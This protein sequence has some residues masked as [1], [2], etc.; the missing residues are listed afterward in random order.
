MI[1]HELAHTL[2][3]GS[4]SRARA[5]RISIALDS[6]EQGVDRLP[7]RLR[8]LPMQ[9]LPAPPILHRQPQ[10]K[11]PIGSPPGAE[12]TPLC[13]STNCSAIS[14]DRFE[15]QPPELQRVLAASLQDPAT[16]LEHLDSDRR[17]ALIGIFNRMCKYG[18]WC[19]VRQFLKIEPGDLPV[20][21]RFLIPGNTSSAHFVSRPWLALYNALMATGRFCQ[22]SGPGASRHPGQTTLREIS[23]SDSLHISLGPG[24]L[25]DAHID[26]YSPVTEHP[27]GSFCP[28]EPSAAAVGHIGRE[29]VPELVRKGVNIFGVHI[30]GPPG[31]QVFPEPP[32]SAPLP[33]GVGPRLSPE[34]VRITTLRGPTKK[35]PKPLVQAEAESASPSAGVLSAEI[36]EKIRQALD[37]QVSHEALLPSPVRASVTY[38]REAAEMAGPGEEAA[39]RAAREAVE[40]KASEY[41]DA[42]DVAFDLA[43]AME[44]ARWRH[45]ASVRLDLD[46]Y[47]RYGGLDPNG[48]KFIVGEI[49]RIALILRNYLPDRAAGVATVVLIFGSDKEAVREEVRLP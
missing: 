39:L 25:F 42:H 44:Q 38:A 20:A 9:P 7:A 16:W 32:P 40:K 45:L 19:H 2:Q 29:L 28:N 27:A 24:D 34:L 18:V 6:P 13:A 12:L 26:H 1:A 36:V 37:Q 48:R 10:L 15:K 8:D 23:G 46:R 47:G 30:P 4:G 41:T 11:P 33:E 5:K 22:A 49:R 35:P 14:G 43:A 3:Q 21:D 17:I 31:F